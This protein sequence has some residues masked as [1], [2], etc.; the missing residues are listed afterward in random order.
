MDYICLV[1]ALQ[2][3]EAI[4]AL[5]EDREKSCANSLN[6][7]LLLWCYYAWKKNPIEVSDAYD[8]TMIAVLPSFFSSVF[9]TRLNIQKSLTLHGLALQL[10]PLLILQ[11]DLCVLL[12][13]LTHTY[14]GIPCLLWILDVAYCLWDLGSHPNLFQLLRRL[15]LTCIIYGSVVKA[16]NHT[17]IC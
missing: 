11:L 2:F 16:R 3:T 6:P 9:Y 14:C 10:L 7:E 12:P 5:E 1:S 13:Q 15:L 8:S 4:P 17:T